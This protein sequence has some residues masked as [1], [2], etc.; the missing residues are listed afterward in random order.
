M[1]YSKVEPRTREDVEYLPRIPDIQNFG[2][3]RMVKEDNGIALYF[4]E[5]KITTVDV[6]S[7]N[8][9]SFDAGVREVYAQYNPEKKEWSFSEHIRFKPNGQPWE[10][11]KFDE[12]NED[13]NRII[14]ILNCSK[15]EFVKCVKFFRNVRGFYKSNEKERK[16]ID[17][18]V[19]QHRRNTRVG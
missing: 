13:G 14:D 5:E 4:D 18:L 6:Y 10:A 15:P 8:H 1:Y 12:F 9:F 7:E 16:N 17:R 19:I 2:Y 3:T 11:S